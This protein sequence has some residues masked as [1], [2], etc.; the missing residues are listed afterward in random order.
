MSIPPPPTPSNSLEYGHYRVLLRPDGTP[1]TLGMGGMGVTYKATDTRLHVDVALKVIHPLH[2]ADPEVQRLFVREARAAARVVHFNVAPVV[3]LHD[4][5]GRV[6]YAMEFVDGISLHAWLRRGE[7]PRVAQSLA[8]A[9]QI[10]AGLAAIHEQNIIHRDLKPANVMVVQYP[11]EHPRHRSLAASGGCLLKIIDFGLARG[12]TGHVFEQNETRGVQPTIGFRG[13]VA[14]A[15]PEQCEE[16]PDLDGRSDLYAL[17][18]MLWEM[19]AGKP[20]FVGASVH[21]VMSQQISKA[22]PLDEIFGAPPETVAVV[23]RLLE[24]KRARRFPDAHAA[25]DALEDARRKAGDA[26]APGSIRAPSTA[27]NAS[28]RGPTSRTAAPGTSITL[29]FPS[30]AGLFGTFLLLALAG[31]GLAWWI[32]A[33]PSRGPRTALPAASDSRAI[34]VLPFANLSAQKEDEFFADGIHQDVLTTIAKIGALRVIARTA[35]LPYKAGRPRDLPQISR[36][37]GVSS[38]LE[39]SVQRSGK[40]I[41][42]RVQLIAT[43]NSQQL[44]GETFDRDFTDVFAIQTEI[45]SAIAQAL[46][47]NLSPEEKRIIA[48]RPT[49]NLEAYEHYLR[50]RDAETRGGW[51]PEGNYAALVEYDRAATLDPAF[52]LAIVGQAR[53]HARIYGNGSDRSRA[54]AERAREAADR[55]LRLAPNAAETIAAHAEYLFRVERRYD[56]ALAALRAVEKLAPEDMSV[57][58]ITGNVLRRKGRAEDAIAYFRR[59][60]RVAPESFDPPGYLFTSL[61]RVR[62]FD[63]LVAMSEAFVPRYTSPEIRAYVARARALQANDWNVSLNALRELDLELRA[64]VRCAYRFDRRDFKGALEAL[65][66]VPGE[67]MVADDPPN[68]VIPKSFMRG[69]ILVRLGEAAAARPEF[70][71]AAHWMEYALS[72]RLDDPFLEIFLARA[73]A[74]LGRKDDALRTGEAAVRRVPESLDAY[75]GCLVAH[76]FAL[77]CAEVGEPE[78]ACALLRHLLNVPST[79]QRLL[80]RNL[81]CY[82]SLRE[83]PEFQAL[84]KE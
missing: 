16:A 9:E 38:V 82:D 53:C 33:A 66:A 69:L 29:R 45:A 76:S 60:Q 5:P 44:W 41:R 48:L 83:H 57:L 51:R 77:V 14:Y 55:A 56:D 28:G 12:I 27:R 2:V 67:T 3:Y 49:E 20:P 59:A 23:Q 7:R 25:V 40:K 62:R 10:A 61:I 22:P 42:V 26:P 4:E 17:G 52:A 73:H 71:Q 1:W 6:F 13:T 30:R 72:E 31:A 43:S 50:G 39:G 15:S 63:E 70:E 80:L 74:A 64:E 84:V 34:A 54:E 81:P 18:C 46:A 8:F 47:A 24:K 65:E 37:L 75:D 32:Y 68:V 36:D 19:L 21:V 58:I 35:V 11:P 79:V 78:R